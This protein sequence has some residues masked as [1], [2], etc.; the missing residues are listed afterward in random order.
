MTFLPNLVAASMIWATRCTLD[1]NVATI[2]RCFVLRIM[3]WISLATF[4]SEIEKSSTPEF[5][6]SDINKSGFVTPINAIF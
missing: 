4:L 2:K 5:V 1:A 6:E 3:S